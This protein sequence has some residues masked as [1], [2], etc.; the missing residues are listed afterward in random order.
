MNYDI[1]LLSTSD[2]LSTSVLDSKYLRLYL[3]EIPYENAELAQESNKEIVYYNDLS[4]SIST[5]G[6]IVKKLSAG[7]ITNLETST[8]KWYRLKIFIAKEDANGDVVEMKEDTIDPATGAILEAGNLNK[9][10]TVKV[11]IITKN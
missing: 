9:E 6:N 2:I 7:T 11:G 4:D 8:T 1:T 3:S 10:F 5:N